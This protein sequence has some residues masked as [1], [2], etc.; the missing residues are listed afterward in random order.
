MLQLQLDAISTR[1]QHLENDMRAIT[2][3]MEAEYIAVPDREQAKN[4]HQF[5]CSQCL[6]SYPSKSSLS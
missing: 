3:R 4:D 5:L 2:K 6:K 1:V